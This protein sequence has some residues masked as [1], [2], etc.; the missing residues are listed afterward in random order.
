MCE[1]LSCSAEEDGSAKH[2]ALG[3]GH[4]LIS[5]RLKSGFHSL[6]TR[7]ISAGMAF[8]LGAAKKLH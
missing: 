4:D 2:V 6:M 8:T 7:A 5:I 3:R 1:R